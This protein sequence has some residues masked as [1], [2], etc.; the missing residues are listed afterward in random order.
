[1]ALNSN[2]I[3]TPTR[4]I[5]HSN[6]FLPQKKKIN[7]VKLAKK[8]QLRNK[9][10]KNFEDLEQFSDVEKSQASTARKHEEEKRD[11]LFKIVSHND[12]AKLKIDIQK[13]IRR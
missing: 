8:E 10:I 6:D 2:L 13:Q 5:N 1:L 9:K 11:M 12:I 7:P 3:D 4:L